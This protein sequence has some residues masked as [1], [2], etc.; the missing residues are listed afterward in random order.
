MRRSGLQM[1]AFD[2]APSPFGY[3][4]DDASYDYHYEPRLGLQDIAD[5]YLYLRSWKEY[6][7]CDWLEGY[8]SAKMFVAQKPFYQAFGIQ[9]GK[10][11][12]N[13]D[14]VNRLFEEQ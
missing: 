7:Q 14:A 11:L 6:T 3:L 2:T 13:A 9:A 5:G 12:K 10:H 8:V 4:R 1:A